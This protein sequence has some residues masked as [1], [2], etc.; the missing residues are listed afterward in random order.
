MPTLSENTA[1][2]EPRL[3]L[4]ATEV[5]AALLQAPDGCAPGARPVPVG[6]ALRATREG[7][8]I[9][10]ARLVEQA[11]PRDGPPIQARVA[12][13]DGAEALQQQLLA[14]FPEHTLVLDIIH[15]TEYLWDVANALRGDT[16]PHRTAWV[17]S[18]PEPLVA[19]QTEA[20]LTA[21]EAAAHDPTCTAIQRHAVR[22][23]VGYDRRNRPY[24][25]D[26]EY[27]AQ[28][29]P[30]GTGVI[31]GACRHLVKD[32]K[33]RM[34][35]SG[36]LWTKAGA[37]VVF[38]LRAVRLNGQWE[39]YWQFHRHQQ[40]RQL[41]GTSA[42]VPERADAQALTLAAEPHGYPRTLITLD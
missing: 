38:E 24:M 32:R 31:E 36:M 10:M 5:V 22:R 29:W 11:M 4:L 3:W 21:L 19:G 7:K 6:K 20:V 23:T 27:L 15:A 13:T 34:E 40:H 18:D 25:H 9:G 16:P 37:Q 2:A 8:A 12:L 28:G 42:Q 14:R 1:L 35:L 39:A 33:D 17:R 41:Y 30:I 26:D